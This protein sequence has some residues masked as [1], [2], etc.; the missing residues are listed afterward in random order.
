MLGEKIKVYGYPVWG[1]KL[2]NNLYQY[3]LEFTIDE[4]ERME[5]TRLLNQVQIKMR[6]NVLFAEGNFV[7]QNPGVYFKMN[8]VSY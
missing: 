8:D 7:P 1:E 3:G 2:E 5:L 6:K 4:N